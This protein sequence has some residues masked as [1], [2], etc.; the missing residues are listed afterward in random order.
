MNELCQNIRQIYTCLGDELSK[1]I[2]SYRLLYYF[3]GDNY[4]INKLVLTTEEGRS[5]ADMLHADGRKKV[6]FGVGSWGKAI[7]KA[8]P[9]VK[10]ECFVDNH[11]RESIESG[12]PVIPFSEYVEKFRDAIIIISSRIHYQEMWEQLLAADIPEEN[13]INA[14]KINDE[15]CM[16]QYFDLPELKQKWNSGG[17]SLVDAGCLDGSSSIFFTKWCSGNYKKIWGF[18]P[19]KENAQRCEKAFELHGIKNYVVLRKGLWSMDTKLR[20]CAASN[21]LSK[22]AED[23]D[24][25]VEVVK[26]DDVIPLNEK[27]TFIKMDIEGAE[28]EALIG[29]K[30]IIEEQKPKL[31][32]SVYHK[33]EDIVDISSLILSFNKDYR[34]YLRHY[35][36]SDFE[37]VL[38]AI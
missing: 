7:V 13:I 19:D 36:L 12:I 33:P 10:F 34:L 15:F 14:G 2:F 9:D 22:I 31:A 29:A 1:E 8:F 18:E 6:M 23:G 26:L 5:F 3:F 30:K 25:L 16:K 27:I 32:I 17:E 24:D 28:Y 20:F 21:G 38:Y 35:S 11:I 4:L 37:T